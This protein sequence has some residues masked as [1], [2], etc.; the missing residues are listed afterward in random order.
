[1]CAPEPVES[2][3]QGS[4]LG[5]AGGEDCGHGGLQHQ[6]LRLH[7][8]GQ[9]EQSRL[10]GDVCMM[11]SDAW[12]GCVKYSVAPNIS[13]CLWFAVLYCLSHVV[14]LALKC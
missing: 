8:V 7:R 5:P 3:P 13:S 10:F 2:T 11:F 1:M 9:G 4:G 14:L 12:E 6:S